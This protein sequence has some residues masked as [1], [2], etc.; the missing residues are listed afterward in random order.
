MP[1]EYT[2]LKNAPELFDT[3]PK[4]KHTPFKSFMRGQVQKNKYIIWP[5]IKREKYCAIICNECNNIVGYEDPYQ[6]IILG[7]LL[8]D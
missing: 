6:S 7:I 5:F 8:Q 1:I 3:C 4:C 2:L